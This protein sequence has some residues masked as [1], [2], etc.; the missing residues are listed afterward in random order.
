MWAT[1]VHLV[2]SAL[3]PIYIASHASLSRPASAAKPTKKKGGATSGEDEE[4]EVYQRMEGLA[5]TDALLFPLFAGI[6]LA[7][8]YFLIKWL[9]DPAILNKILGYYFGF[10]GIFGVTKLVGDIL[11]VAHSFVF[12][13]WYRDSD[14]VW[15]VSAEKREAIPFTKPGK[16]TEDMPT[17]LRD[18]PLPGIFGRLHLPTSVNNALWSFRELPERKLIFKFYIHRLAATR[19]RLGVFG[20]I[21]VVVGI[22]AA[23]Y[24]NFVGKPWWLTNLFGFSFCY[25]ALQLM[26]PTTF[27]TGTLILSGLFFYDIYMVFF[28]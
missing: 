15:Q 8:L 22:I 14:V 3:F 25:T 11:H 16:A 5:P 2:L 28:T 18:G 24:S 13:K 6:T 21:G 12:P 4:E 27:A 26:S 17:I 7:G 10:M 1:Y 9:E 19:V 23:V 20:A